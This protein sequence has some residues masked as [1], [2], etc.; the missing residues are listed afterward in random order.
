MPVTFNRSSTET[1][2]PHENPPIRR[3]SHGIGKSLFVWD[4]VVGLGGLELPTK[5]LSVASSEQPPSMARS[6]IASASLASPTCRRNGPDSIRCS[7]FLRSNR[8]HTR[9]ESLW[10]VA[11]V[12]GNGIFA[13]KTKPPKPFIEIQLVTPGNPALSGTSREAGR[14]S[15][16]RARSW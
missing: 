3:Y 1:K 14:W 11:S 6:R 9:T 4:C 5:R 10:V 2:S 15:M 12:R 13:A 16:L 8:T 7:A